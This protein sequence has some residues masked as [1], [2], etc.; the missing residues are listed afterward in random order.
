ME[1][2]QKVAQNKVASKPL[3]SHVKGTNGKQGSRFGV[4][5]GMDNAST[6]GLLESEKALI[7][8]KGHKVERSISKRCIDSITSIK[9][10]YTNGIEK[11]GMSNITKQQQSRDMCAKQSLMEDQVIGTQGGTRSDI[12]GVYGSPRQ[13]QRKAI[14]KR[15]EDLSDALDKPWVVISDFNAYLHPG[16]KKGGNRSIASSMTQF[17]DC[18]DRNWL[19]F[20][21]RNTRFFHTRNA[22][23]CFQK[24]DGSLVESQQNLM[25]HIKS[26]YENL[27][28]DEMGVV[29][30]PIRGNFPHLTVGQLATIQ[31]VPTVQEIK[32]VIFNMGGLKAPGPD[33]LHPIFFQSQWDTIGASTCNRVI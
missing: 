10:L 12:G 11:T 8:S 17:Q 32:T 19:K 28:Q 30:W 31:E 7:P 4:L 27:F 22:I 26:F 33:G 15:I 23:K 2:Q 5:Y 6:S 24:D 9:N 18:L 29:D 16:E 25:L 14:W 1:K 21:D 3:D 20:G 13:Q